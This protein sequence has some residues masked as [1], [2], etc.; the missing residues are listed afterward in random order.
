MNRRILFISIAVIIL[1]IAGY[2][3]IKPN[4]EE[5]NIDE[6][7][8]GI[9]NAAITI[10]EFSD[11]E[12]PFCGKYSRE[13][14][15][16]IEENYIK[17]GKVKYIFRNFPLR[18]HKNSDKSAQAAECAN[19]Q[20][21]F[22]EYHKILFERQLDWANNPEKLKDYAQELALDKERFD[23]CLD[24]GKYKWEVKQDFND[25]LNLGISGTPTFFIN[26]I[27]VVGAQ[28]FDAFKQI[29]EQELNKSKA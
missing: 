11:F 27:K 6:P 15:P 10:T 22:W 12:C 16:L 2:F 1:A 21:K 18:I 4:S 17:T 14:F 23:N 19:E 3:I 5:I 29:I 7:V 13:V 24:S 26:N 9:S 8:I 25:G 28:S 20:G